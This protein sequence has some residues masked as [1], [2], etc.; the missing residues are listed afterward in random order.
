MARETSTRLTQHRQ[1]SITPVGAETRVSARPVDTFVAPAV[2]G[3][4]AGLLEGLSALNP[5]VARL[6]NVTD[7]KDSEAAY[8][9]GQQAGLEPTAPNQAP[10]SMPDRV[11]PAFKD[12]FALGYRESIGA[13]LSAESTEALMAGYNA[14]RLKPSFNAES[15]IAEFQSKELAGV[16]DPVVR[17]ALLKALPGSIKA[18]RQDAREVQMA[19]LKENTI[20][21]N[22]AS[23]RSAVSGDQDPTT[24]HASMLG[25]MEMAG[26]KNSSGF[27]SKVELMQ[28]AF[29]Q[30]QAL[31]T[32]AGGDPAVFSVFDIPFPAG[33]DQAGKTM[34]DLNAGL[35]DNIESARKLATAQRD[36][37]IKQGME[38]Q[39]YAQDLKWQQA[40]ESG[41]LPPAAEFAQH[42]GPGK[43]F[44][45]GAAAFAKYESLRSASAKVKDLTTA[46]SFIGA[47]EAWKLA[48]LPK[49]VRDAA[50]N[51]VTGPMVAALL[52]NSPGSQGAN[53]VAFKAAVESLVK[54]HAGAGADMHSAQLKAMMDS[55]KAAAPAKGAAPS[56]TFLNAAAV[57]KS[58][59]A[60]LRG[61]YA[62]EDSQ[63]ILEQY[64]SGLA[65][66]LD[67]ATAV[68]QAYTAVA[69]ETKEAAAKWAK[70]PANEDAV[71]GW[72]KNLPTSWLRD[73]FGAKWMGTYPA[74]ESVM[75]DWAFSQAKAWKLRNP[76]GDEGQLKSYIKAETEQRWL[77]DKVTNKVIEVPRGRTGEHYEK[78]VGETTSALSTD[79]VRLY[80]EGTSTSLIKDASGDSYTVIAY[81]RGGGHPVVM[82]QTSLS[83]MEA[84]FTQQNSLSPEERSAFGPLQLKLRKGTITAEELAANDGLIRK[85]K[86][87]KWLDGSEVSRME[88]INRTASQALFA[89]PAANPPQM[90]PPMAGSLNMNVIDAAPKAGGA[91]A[92]LA[93]A[94]HQEGD[95]TAAL[96]TMGEGVVL[97]ASPDPATGAGNNIGIGYNF[98]GRGSRVAADFAKAK[99]PNDEASI[100]AIKEGRMAISEEQ[101]Q[102]LL[103]AVLP[104]YKEIARKAVEARAAGL[105]DRLPEHQRAVLTDVAYQVGDVTQFKTAL[106]HLIAG[107]VDDFGAALKVRYR[108][109]ADGAY[110]ADDPRN[111]LR[112]LM[113]SQGS[114]LFMT[115]INEASRK[116]ASKLAALRQP[117][118]KGPLQFGPA[119]TFP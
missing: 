70:D 20:S 73:T 62:S 78:V 57:Y 12:N 7:A 91:K 97:R 43:M 51:Q 118:E 25:W 28:M 37:R 113:L 55:V 66:G 94:F 9:A 48:G 112:S 24:M 16:N 2:D 68:G 8:R 5:A 29:T 49:D 103:K 59:P 101:A 69:P 52:Q 22:A 79:A 71:R 11:V 54:V 42:I 30:V 77:Y 65:S 83:E 36:A 86:A 60:N 40:A 50:M 105:W 64:N 13:K 47:G 58:L 53:P 117:G 95:A 1:T 35:K 80:G 114:Q 61:L 100:T 4:M 93:A 41:N 99:I 81:P 27:Q 14:E 26:G 106:G 75:Q 110:V 21:S 44:A 88:S 92:R 67:A 102:R 85:A 15:F 89:Q 63:A 6:A 39:F 98:K 56:Q 115:T 76:N 45:N 3:D 109:G 23:L 108:K 74:N 116:P 72:A 17:D 18:I 111:N 87:A 82:G 90:F 84:K 38:T 31:S 96:V 10:E 107:K 104:E 119:I 46:V 32:A 19:R 33:H 34:S